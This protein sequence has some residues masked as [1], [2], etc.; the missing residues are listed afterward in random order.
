MEKTI[1]VLA[2]TS[3]D[4]LETDAFQTTWDTLKEAKARAKYYLTE[5][6]AQVSESARL[7]YAQVLV[8][9]ECVADFFAKEAR[10]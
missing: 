7:G 9:G 6:Y 3:Q 4:T 8:N 1:T 10:R 5:E 2:A